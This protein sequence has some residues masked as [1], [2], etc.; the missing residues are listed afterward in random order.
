MADTDSFPDEDQVEY[1]DDLLG[2]EEVT[3]EDSTDT[4][5]VFFYNS[6]HFREQA[7]ATAMDFVKINGKNMGYS[8][9]DVLAFAD[10]FEAYLRNGAA[11]AAT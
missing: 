6:P 3:E 5:G 10:M 8:V 4:G 1:P 11:K 9:T 7:L 2:F